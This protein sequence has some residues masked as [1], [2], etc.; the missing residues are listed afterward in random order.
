MRRCPQ[1]EPQLE[2][3]IKV[4]F[5]KTFLRILKFRKQS[6]HQTKNNKLSKN[7]SKNSRAIRKTFA[8]KI[9]IKSRRKEFEFDN[10]EEL[11]LNT[12]IGYDHFQKVGYSLIIIPPPPPTTSKYVTCFICV[13]SK[14]NYYYYYFKLWDLYEN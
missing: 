8:D 6:F 4:E 12:S 11:S 5:L 13:K 14:I 2:V 9:G 7:Q 10:A 3:E 1:I